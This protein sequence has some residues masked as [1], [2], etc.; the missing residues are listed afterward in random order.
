MMMKKI[1]NWWFW[2]VSR[3]QT[4]FIDR[5]DRFDSRLSSKRADDYHIS[6]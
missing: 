1:K 4:A 2:E 6:H 3:M 5:I